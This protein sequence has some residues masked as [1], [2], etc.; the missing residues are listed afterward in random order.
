MTHIIFVVLGEF[1]KER[2]YFMKATNY[3]DEQTKKLIEDI[4]ENGCW[5]KNPRPVWIDK[6]ENGNEVKTPAYTLSLN[7]RMITYDLSKG[8][9]PIITLRPTAWKNSIKELL[10]IYQDQSNSLDVLEEKYDIHWWNEWDIGDR[11][12]GKRYGATIKGHNLMNELLD[13]LKN[14][15][16]GRRHILSMWQVDDFNDKTGGTTK[17]LNPCAFQTIW[18]VRHGRDGIDYL[19]MVLVQRSSDFITA[20]SINQTQY[21]VFLCMVAH[22]LGYTP[23]QFTW[24]IDNIQIYDRHVDAA[25]EMLQRDSVECTPIVWINPDVKDW[26]DFTPD[27]VKIVG[28]PTAEIKEVN[29]QIKLD[30]AV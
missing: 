8:Q 28:Y 9:L 26:Y 14:N 12:I 27:D 16:D 11:T 1:E 15:P 24:F 3:A 4:L 19:D 30:I 22:V 13:G 18:N 17:G 23:G 7:H 29:P 5:D 21:A 6:D 20:G 10:W 2:N 25:K